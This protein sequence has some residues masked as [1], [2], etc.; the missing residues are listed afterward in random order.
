MRSLTPQVLVW[1]CCTIAIP[2]FLQAGSDCMSDLTYLK[3]CLSTKDQSYLNKAFY[4]Y[5][6]SGKK[7]TR[8]MLARIPLFEDAIDPALRK[9]D[10][11][12]WIKYLPLAESRLQN[13]A[14]S[15]AGA[16]GLWQIMP[17]T[18]KGLGLRIN[19]QVD[20]RF[21]SGKASR[22]AARYLKQLHRQFGDW[23]LALAAYNCG[24]GNV[25][26]A[27]RR[28]GGYYYHEISRYLPRQTQR[29][30]PR[31][32][33]IASI[34]KHPERYGFSQLSKHTAP[35]AV[36]F[37]TATSLDEVAAYF[38][39]DKRILARLNPAFQTGWC[40]LEAGSTAAI[41]LPARIFHSNRR[42]SILRL[43][44]A[45]QEPLK[46]CAYE[47]PT[48][49]TLKFAYAEESTPVSLTSGLLALRVSKGAT[50][51]SEA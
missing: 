11:P 35:V 12:G 45:L 31:V 48:K 38:C 39:C 23:L 30:I 4:R 40:P 6:Q 28:A 21:H 19:Q 29:Y 47:I 24:A 8:D 15:P 3:S 16:A 20:E 22:A 7:E 41:Y 27:Q 42:A 44:M 14:V 37:T 43:G 2:S 46:S 50:T 33:A 10:I 49:P 32:L 34:A 36:S 9:Y 13:K 25:R 1:L 5:T 18:G 51:S 26:K 17:A